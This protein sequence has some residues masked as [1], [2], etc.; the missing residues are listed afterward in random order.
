M[1]VAALEHAAAMAAIHASAFP[2]SEAWSAAAIAAQLALPGTAGLLAMEGGMA[3]LRVAGD[4]AEILT[5][6]VHPQA[7][8]RGLGRGLLAAAMTLAAGAGATAML[9][10]AA[11][12]NAAAAA[13]YAGAG[14]VPVG[15][16]P[17]YYPTGEAALV[18]RAALKPS[19]SAG[20]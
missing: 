8:R 4:E 16:R 12:D 2:A 15:R 17:R 6:A 10:E 5:L 9:L 1:I 18:L 3:L 19:G 20:S 11:E 14:F 7:R 13:L